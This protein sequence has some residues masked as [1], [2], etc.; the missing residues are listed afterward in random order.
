MRKAFVIAGREYN[1]AV[2]T[3]SFLI[4]LVVLPVMIGGAGFMQWMLRNQVD[5][6]ADFEGRCRQVV[7][8][9][10]VVA[11]AEQLRKGRPFDQRRG[12]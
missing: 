11:A 4:S 1:A 9:F 2:R 3:R 10:Q 6:A 7:F 12:A 5:T 8:M